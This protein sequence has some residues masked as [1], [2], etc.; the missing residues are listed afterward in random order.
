MWPADDTYSIL[1]LLCPQPHH[2]PYVTNRGTD[3]HAPQPPPPR[4]ASRLPRS[5]VTPTRLPTQLPP[6][7]RSRAVT[8][9][10]TVPKAPARPPAPP[11]VLV[12]VGKLRNRENMVYPSKVKVQ[13]AMKVPENSFQA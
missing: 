7:F 9:T 11:R 5:A 13:A 4:R 6:P 2:G 3:G 12:C 1:Y 8:P 10:D